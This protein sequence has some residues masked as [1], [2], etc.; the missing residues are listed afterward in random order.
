MP[1][2]HRCLLDSLSASEAIRSSD[3][4]STF[5]SEAAIPSYAP[6]F[7]LEPTYL[8]LTISFDFQ[9]ESI[10]GHVRHTIKNPRS[11]V[12]AAG[13]VLA[14]ELSKITLNAV[15]MDIHAVTDVG[16]NAL[17]Y[18]YDGKE[19]RI[20]W[21]DAFKPSE[22]RIVEIK[23]KVEKPIAGLYF[24]VPDAVF[25]DHVIH[26]I[27]DHETERAR[28]WL[29]C[30]DFPAVRTTLEFH[31]TADKN[32]TALANGA[33]TGVKDN[34]DGT[35]TTSYHLSSLCP[36]YL[37]CLAVGDFIEAV[38]EP[39]GDMPIKY[40]APRNFSK[41][42]LLTTFGRTPAMIKWMQEK[43]GYKFPWPKYYQIASEEVL[44]GAMENISLVTYTERFLI[45]EIAAKDFSDSVES[46]NVHEMAHTYFGDLLVIRHFE[47][48][49]LKEGW[50][51]YFSK[52]W[53]ED[54]VSY[55]EFRY[56]M[57][58]DTRDYVTETGS[59]IR[60]LVT[61]T[62]DSSWSLF[63]NH[64]Y[65][66]GSLRIHMLR[67]LLGDDV[68]WAAVKNYVAT[69]ANKVV[70]T[71]DFKRCLEQ[72]SGLNLTRFF[73][74]W[75]YGRG[76]PK[77]KASY[78]F[79]SD[80]KRVQITL[81][82][83][84]VNKK[85]GIPV[86]DIAIEVD[87]IDTEGKT[88]SVSIPFAEN[89]AKAVGFIRVGDAKPSI[90]EIDPR[91]KVLH[92]LEFSPGEAILE[93]NAK[94]GRDI[95]T[96]I[97]AYKEL[98]KTASV[99]AFKKV[100]DLLPQEK[101]FGVRNFAYGALAGSKTQAAIDILA[102]SLMVETEPRALKVLLTK[103]T[104]RDAGIRKGLL[105]ILKDTSD[106]TYTA[107]SQAY[108]NLGR[109]RHP[110]DLALLL[111]A[112]AIPR[113]GPSEVAR[114]GVMRGL[115]LHRSEEAYRYLLTRLPRGV[116]IARV[117]TPVIRALGDIGK[118]QSKTE[119]MVLAE[120]VA[121]HL[122]DPHPLVKFAVL[123]TLTA[124][125]ASSYASAANG[126]LS[127]FP[128]Q[129]K[130]DVKKSIQELRESDSSEEKIKTLTSTVEGLETRLKKLEQ[131]YQ[132]SQAKLKEDAEKAKEAKEK[133][134]KEKEVK[135]E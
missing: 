15:S 8:A 32:F 45:D 77:I 9:N 96:R 75:I 19:I 53:R 94:G 41:E 62:Y 28:Y 52:L 11:N 78:D 134:E 51:T 38:D 40:Y 126:M 91:G 43:V 83:T 47:H 27:T 104:I 29:P 72:E 3:G 122:L 118:W 50:A 76:F 89:D 59:Y 55:D 44:G 107:L 82:Q 22:S 70:E 65:P 66:G 4:G 68:F 135:K 71:E 92:S 37:I 31:L 63:D 85:E 120:L 48:A 97:H 24:H 23:Y 5:C 49:W 110:D 25:K 103:C 79:D 2:H 20:Q 112:A 67:Q 17:D 74:Q 61:R 101:F 56:Y 81:E 114:T 133:E 80:K 125:E 113:T 73:D 123:D 131:Q 7:V 99:S 14:K 105:H 128:E 98:I 18:D 69:F 117:W 124:L 6:N 35:K 58:I 90:V 121:E 30:V 108:T 57:L 33:E 95:G 54:N 60:P 106:L 21:K 34:G 127:T 109:Q 84:Q 93:A 115:G 10:A 64:I 116:E 119:K 86:F 87:V 26:C 102:S 1:C 46:V 39:V 12:P 13:S 16:G 129:E 100:M 111:E 36:S 130:G 42:D 88:F 132:L